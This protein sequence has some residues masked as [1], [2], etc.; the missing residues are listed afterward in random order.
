MFSL[1]NIQVYTKN[2]YRPL[3]KS[4]SSNFMI[5]DQQKSSINCNSPMA[6]K[7]FL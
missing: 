3:S 4:K 1:T 6:E 5:A 2:S 7:P